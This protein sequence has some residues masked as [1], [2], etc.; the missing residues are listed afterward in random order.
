MPFK[1]A[2]L[3]GYFLFLTDEVG[4]NFKDAAVFVLLSY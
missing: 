3:L 4:H 2:L 1:D